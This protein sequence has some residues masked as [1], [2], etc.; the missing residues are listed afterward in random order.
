M[1]NLEFKEG[2]IVDGRITGVQAYGIFVR[3]SDQCSGLV[4][5]SELEKLESREPGRFFKLGQTIKVKVLKARPGG[6]QFILKI[7]REK[8]SSR[9]VGASNFETATGFEALRNKLPGWVEQAKQKGLVE[10]E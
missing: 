4:H 5:A 6:T 7:Y 1:D 9:R 3:L 2:D 10:N 8:G